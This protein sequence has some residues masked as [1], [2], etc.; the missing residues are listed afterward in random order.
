[1][2]SA[3]ITESQSHLFTT[4]LH[5][6]VD[7]QSPQ[8]SK[9]KTNNGDIK[10][11]SHK[12]MARSCLFLIR[13]AERVDDMVTQY[14]NELTKQSASKEAKFCFADED[15]DVTL[16]GL[17][18]AIETGKAVANKIHK[19]KSENAIPKDVKPR[20]IVSPY[21]RCIKTAMK[22]IEGMKNCKMNIA[23]DQFFVEDAVTEWQND[24]NYM[25][26]EKNPKLIF[27]NI[28]ESSKVK[29]IGKFD[30]RRNTL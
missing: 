18:Q 12:L 20:I 22:L 7:G 6:V 4:P 8:M 19:L 25:L 14:K 11:N 5:T 26:K 3:N 10:E 27:N 2:K 15:P 24:P 9:K 13:H 21:W 30:F 1:M 23:D 17:Q 16:Y 28:K 29:H